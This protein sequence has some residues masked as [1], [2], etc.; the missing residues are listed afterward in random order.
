MLHAFKKQIRPG[1]I[2]SCILP[3]AVFIYLASGG[4]LFAAEA[5]FQFYAHPTTI[6]GLSRESSDSPLLIATTNGTF[7]TQTGKPIR[8]KSGD[9]ILT[10]S[11]DGRFEAMLMSHIRRPVTLLISRSVDGL[12]IG[13][14]FENDQSHFETLTVLT[15]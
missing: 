4:L 9:A 6:T 14:I 13:A 3:L 5:T 11:D 12:V 15:N 8:T 1:V 2:L 7:F 10:V